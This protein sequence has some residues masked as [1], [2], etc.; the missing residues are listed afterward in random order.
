MSR[1]HPGSEGR[2]EKRSGEKSICKGPEAE[3]LWLVDGSKEDQDGKR[4]SKGERT[5][6]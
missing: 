2:R 3:E 5:G 6:Y 1:S 4:M